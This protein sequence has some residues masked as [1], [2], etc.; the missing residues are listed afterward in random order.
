MKHM[1]PTVPIPVRLD[2]RTRGR[3]DRAA[4]K[5]GSNRSSVIRFAVINQ[6]PQI[7][8]GKITLAADAEAA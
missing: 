3:L 2:D 8:A 4:K 6:L 5:M 7:E 1:E